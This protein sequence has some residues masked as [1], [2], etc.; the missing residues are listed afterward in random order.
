MGHRPSENTVVFA[1]PNLTI[2]DIIIKKYDTNFLIKKEKYE[3]SHNL[4]NMNFLENVLNKK[5]H[6]NKKFMYFIGMWSDLI[7]P[8]T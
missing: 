5:N 1:K 8:D 2:T 7:E 4:E 6:E 3:K